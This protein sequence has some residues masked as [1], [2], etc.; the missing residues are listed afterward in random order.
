[1]RTKKTFSKLTAFYKRI[2]RILSE[3]GAQNIMI[4]KKVTRGSGP[5]TCYMNIV[6][7][8]D[9][10]KKRAKLSLIPKYQ[11]QFA[12]MTEYRD[13][14]VFIVSNTQVKTSEIEN[15]VYR[16]I[17]IWDIGNQSELIFERL[18]KRDTRV[19]VVEKTKD[20]IDQHKHIDY[21][22]YIRDVDNTEFVVSVDVKSSLFKGK[23]MKRN[24]DGTYKVNAGE[25]AVANNPTWAEEVINEILIWEQHKLN[26]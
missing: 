4:I 11:D 14:L 24:D 26:S 23:L 16:I 22:V 6:F 1:M 5:G 10:I 3:V 2:Q 18:I 12:I 19:V 17:D 7:D 15:E 21:I 8:F 13:Q 25:A 20:E 9:G